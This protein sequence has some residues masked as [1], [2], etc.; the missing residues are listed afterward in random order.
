MSTNRSPIHRQK[1]FT[2]LSEDVEDTSSISKLN[3]RLGGASIVE[4]RRFSFGS[5]YNQ[6]HSPSY[7]SRCLTGI[8][9]WEMQMYR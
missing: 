5:T 8:L 9:S 7:R 3:D 6:A 2:E 4:G 1:M